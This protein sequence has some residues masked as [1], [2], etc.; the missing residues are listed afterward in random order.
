MPFINVK[1]NREVG[2]EHQEKVKQRLG[3][4]IELIPGKSEEWLMVAIDD[5]SSL[6]FKGK[7]DKAIAFVEVKIFGSTTK[8]AYQ[9][10]T[11]EI[12]SILKEE[13]NIAADQIFV[14]YSEIDHW[15]WNGNNF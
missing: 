2:K 15:G 5:K 14:V 8:E 9:L 3:K 7:A 11:A 13:L 4:A 1:T 12:T 10:V 6:Y